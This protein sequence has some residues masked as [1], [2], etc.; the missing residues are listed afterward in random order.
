MRDV[1]QNIG[2]GALSPSLERQNIDNL[3]TSRTLTDNELKSIGFKIISRKYIFIIIITRNSNGFG[4]RRKHANF[5]VDDSKEEVYSTLT[6]D[7]RFEQLKEAGVFELMHCMRNC[8]ELQVITCKWDIKS[9]CQII[10]SQAK[11]YIR[12]IQKNLKL[13]T[14]TN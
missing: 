13:S 8:R 4:I 11:V 6:G 10:G 1:F 2:L 12:P 7:T 14:P 3:E 5:K 9:L